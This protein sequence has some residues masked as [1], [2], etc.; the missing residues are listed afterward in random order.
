MFGHHDSN[1]RPLDWKTSSLTNSL[2]PT[3]ELLLSFTKLFITS[4]KSYLDDKI[5]E[6]P[7]QNGKNVPETSSSI[8]DT[9]LPFTLAFFTPK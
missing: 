3:A 7:T 4:I 5:T 9:K 1:S 2:Q 8:M 6:K